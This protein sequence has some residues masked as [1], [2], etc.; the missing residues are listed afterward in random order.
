MYGAKR[1]II[2]FGRFL[3]TYCGDG[4]KSVGGRPVIYIFW[5][6]EERIEWDSDD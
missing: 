3:F 2:L 1:D 4:N 6:G 5:V